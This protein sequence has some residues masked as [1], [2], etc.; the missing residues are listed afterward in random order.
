MCVDGEGVWM[1]RVCGWV[2]VCIESVNGLECAEEY[3]EGVCGGAHL[4]RL[5]TAI[6][7]CLSSTIHLIVCVHV[8]VYACM[9]VYVL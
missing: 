8:N 7:S 9:C 4:R 6:C 2:G 5:K 3:V 1:G